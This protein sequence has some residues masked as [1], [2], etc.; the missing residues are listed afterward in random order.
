LTDFRLLGPLE[1]I[2]EGR[3][4]DLPAGKPKALLA[5]LLLE[6]NR[7]VPVETLLH[8]LWSDAPPSAHKVL[9]GYVS[10]LRKALGR[11][12]IETRSPGYVLNVARDDVDLGRVE[13]LTETARAEASAARRAE[14]L[15][16][17]LALWRGPALAE[18][19]H[20]PFAQPAARRL[21]ELRL[22]AIEQRIEAELAE[23]IATDRQP[24][25]A[26]IAR[27]AGASPGQYR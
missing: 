20:E 9:Q 1:A 10:Q 2:V 14:L 26:E 4:V 5:E 17:A 24:C 16:N 12:F 21:A 3:P 18:F 13:R 15:R 27:V 19:R 22:D 6:A 7:V 23:R 8:A 25:G 11:Q